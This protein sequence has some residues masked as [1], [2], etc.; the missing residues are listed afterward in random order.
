MEIS[1]NPI[2]HLE[3]IPNNV[4]TLNVCACY[5]EKIENLPL[6]LTNLLIHSNPISTIENLPFSL[7][8]L[9]IRACNLRSIDLLPSMLTK[10]YLDLNKISRLENLPDSIESVSY[11]HLPS[12]RDATLS[13]MPSSA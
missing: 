4:D 11:T 3:N 7:K 6:G 12:P 5:I 1:L 10:I 9:D 8:L 13:R 2:R